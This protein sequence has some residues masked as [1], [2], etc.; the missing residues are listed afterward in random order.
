MTLS[1]I[2]NVTDF[3][4]NEVSLLAI[5]SPLTSAWRDADDLNGS[6][7]WISYTGTATVN[8]TVECS[9][10]GG[11]Q[12]RQ[13]TQ[14]DWSK[15]YTVKNGCAAAEGFVAS[16][17]LPMDRPF[18]SYRVIVATDANITGLKVAVCRNGIG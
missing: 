17:A 15:V 13:F 16:P 14:T 4:F 6:Q 12:K 18:G 9:A 8:L 2:R 1:D 10:V 3:V 5:N 11:T 7:F